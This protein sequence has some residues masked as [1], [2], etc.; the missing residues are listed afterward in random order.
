MFTKSSSPSGSV[1]VF[2][3]FIVL[4]FYSLGAGFLES[5]VN[6]PLWRII[7]ETDQW[8]AYHRALGARVIVV[9]AIPALGLSLIANTLLAFFRP[10]G[11][12]GWTIAATLVLLLVATVSTFAIQIPIQMTLDTGYDRAAVDRLISSSL[13]LRDVTGALRAAIAAHMLHLVVRTASLDT[14]HV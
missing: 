10:P 11:V 2:T 9:L 3:A 5:F 14:R 4:T 12:P 13:W 1:A 7:G 8:V 6:Y